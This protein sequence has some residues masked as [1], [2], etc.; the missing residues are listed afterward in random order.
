MLSPNPHRCLSYSSAVAGRKT[1]ANI[2]CLVSLV[3]CIP[4]E[5]TGTWKWQGSLS[6]N[7]FVQTHA[8]AY[9]QISDV[10]FFPTDFCCDLLP[11]A[12]GGR[13]W[14][15]NRVSA[16]Q[17]WAVCEVYMARSCVFFDRQRPRKLRVCG[18]EQRPLNLELVSRGRCWF[19]SRVWLSFEGW[20]CSLMN[21]VHSLRCS[22]FIYQILHPIS[23]DE[24]SDN[25]Y[26]AAWKKRWRLK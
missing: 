14:P 5:R 4:E 25:I 20:I 3:L 17:T 6:H 15:D 13:G 2:T 10:I 19:P 7:T 22:L 1:A 8:T 16:T 21:C 23:W 9:L 24:V 26:R 11:R 18:Q 12:L